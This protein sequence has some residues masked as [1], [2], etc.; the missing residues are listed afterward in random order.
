MN[1]FE[2]VTVEQFTS[3]AYAPFVFKSRGVEGFQKSC[4]FFCAFQTQPLCHFFIESD[5]TCYLGNL[6]H[7]APSVSNSTDPKVIQ[8]YK[9][10]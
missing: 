5:L 7:S 6:D 1:Q 8:M 4:K 2:N 9:R 10:K 3:E